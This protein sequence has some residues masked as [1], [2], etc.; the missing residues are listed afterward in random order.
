MKGFM[1]L[2]MKKRAV[3]VMTVAAVA[4]AANALLSALDQAFAGAS[5][6]VV[7][8]VAAYF[9]DSPGN[10]AA[11]TGRSGIGVVVLNTLQA[12]GASAAV[13]DYKGAGK[14]VFGYLAAGYA[15]SGANGVSPKSLPQLQSTADAILSKER[16]RL[17][18]Y[19]ARTRKR[20][21]GDGGT[22]P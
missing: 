7:A 4:V 13:A 1:K 21:S 10:R 14:R 5:D 20:D 16:A 18:E 3:T 22:A 8:G 12:P 6:P 19:L 11:I 17:A 9:P 15:P 2:T